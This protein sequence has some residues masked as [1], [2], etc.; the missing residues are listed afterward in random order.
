MKVSYSNLKQKRL[1]KK[2]ITEAQKKENKL[3]NKKESK[4]VKEKIQP[5]QEKI[6]SKIPVKLQ[7]S[8]EKAF[9][10]GFKVVFEKG[11][12]IIEKTYSKEV[13]NI[14]FDVNHYAVLN[15][16]TKKNL[17]KLDRTAR[18]SMIINQ[19]LSTAEGG[20]LGA[21]GIG[22]PDIPL[23][24]G[25]MLKNIYEV[26]LSY[27]F[28]YKDKKEKVYILYLICASITQGENQVNYTKLLDE[29]QDDYHKIEADSYNLDVIIKETAHQLADAMLIAKFIQGLPLVGIVG[30]GYN[31]TIMQKINKMAKVKYKKRYLQKLNK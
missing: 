21:L 18:K 15:Q 20:V 28:D 13:K 12:G 3:V 4:L 23:F 11:I 9:E 25:M 2:E 10:T 24:V 22:L 31:F 29:V 27:G 5:L 19:L 26:S 7:Q 30:G 8:L 14:E 1:I 16:T 6:E 17:R